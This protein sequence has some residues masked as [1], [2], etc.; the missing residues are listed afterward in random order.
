MAGEEATQ[1]GEPTELLDL[2]VDTA[3]EGLI[4]L[5]KLRGLTLDG[6]VKLLNSH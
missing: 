2:R 6:V 4:P 1:T 3:L 5:C